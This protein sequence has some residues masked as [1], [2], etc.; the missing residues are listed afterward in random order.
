MDLRRRHPVVLGIGAVVIGLVAAVLA[1]VI[2]SAATDDAPDEPNVDAELRF[3]PEDRQPANSGLV[4]RDVSGDPVPTSTFTKLGGGLGRLTDYDGKPIVVNF[5]GSWCVPCRKEMPALQSVFEDLGGRVAFVGL[6]ISDS[7][8]SAQAFVDEYEVTYDVGRDPSSK[9][10][11]DFGVVVM[12]STFLISPDGM[13]V[14]KHAGAVTAKDLREL[15][16][17]KLDIR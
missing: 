14:A 10:Y 1:A 2:Y 5:F 4:G 17:E 3:G 12:P 16:D 15:L 13:I 6:A 7:E 9:L 11:A 8:K